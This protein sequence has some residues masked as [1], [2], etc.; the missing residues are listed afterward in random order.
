MPRGDV[1]TIVLQLPE[2]VFATDEGVRRVVWSGQ[3]H[4]ASFN[5]RVLK[6]ASRG[7]HECCAVVLCGLAAARL[8]FGLLVSD[9]RGGWL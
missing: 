7:R 4:Q 6:G 8:T 1:I 9:V 2:D 5:V 3:P